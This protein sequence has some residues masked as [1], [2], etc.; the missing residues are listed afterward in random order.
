VLSNDDLEG[1]LRPVDSRGVSSDGSM[2]FFDSP[3]PLVA[4]DTNGVRDV[5]AWENGHVG[6]VSAGTG[7]GNSFFL[8]N[9]EDG[10]DVFFATADGLNPVDTDG[11]ADVY[12]ART[13]GITP[14]VGAGGCVGECQGPP[15]PA[16]VFG[17]PGSFSFA[18]PGNPALPS[19]PAP[20]V[21]SKPKPKA[22]PKV[23][24]KRKKG[25][26]RGKR[27]ALRRGGVR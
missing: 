19:T 27:A 8:D 18:G 14:V 26:R 25:K 10:T 15:S 7:S 3:D 16:P 2:V 4:Q 22:K 23:K 20:V 21:K 13:G 12:D 24:A 6:L 9:S 11:G 1:E 17:V 5:Y